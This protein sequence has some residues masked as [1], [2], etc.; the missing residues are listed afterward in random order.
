M[1]LVNSV[2]NF[3]RSACR[4][5]VSGAGISALFFLAAVFLLVLLKIKNIA[6]CR[7]ILSSNIVYKMSCD[8]GCFKFQ[9]DGIHGCQRK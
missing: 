5:S 2:F 6:L 9:F 7:F 4:P 3:S 8:N 1:L